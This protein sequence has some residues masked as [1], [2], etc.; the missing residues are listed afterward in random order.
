MSREFWWTALGAC[1]VGLGVIGFFHAFDRVTVMKPVRPEPAVMKDRYLAVTRT[2]ERLDIRADQVGVLEAIAPGADVDVVFVEDDRPS[3]SRRAIERMQAFVRAG[4]VVVLEAKWSGEDDPLLDAFGVTRSELRWT[5]ADDGDPFED[6]DEET[7]YEDGDAD[8]DADEDAG[9]EE[10]DADA[11]A[12]DVDYNDFLPWTQR[13][14]QRH[15]PDPNLRRIRWAGGDELIVHLPY[16]QDLARFRTEALL[17]DDHGA[18]ILRFDLGEGQVVVLND[19]DFASN[20]ELARNDHAEFVWRLV[21]LHA[22]PE[23]V[24]FYHADRQDLG[25]WLRKNAWAPLGAIG[26]LVLLL[27]WRGMPRFGP[28]ADDPQP[29]RRR[30][31][32]HLRAT[33]SFLAKANQREDI[34]AAAIRVALARVRREFPHIGIASDVEVRD[35]LVRQFQIQPEGAFLIATQQVPSGVPEWTRLMRACR[36]IHAA[37]DHEALRRT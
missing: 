26:L 23:R 8:E 31:L 17:A 13:L 3:V 32:D 21:H 2:L 18:Y 6:G 20:F 15:F 28:I 27:L 4:G 12:D 25:A 7:E 19:L 30:L 24:W 10:S 5:R 11:V 29:V 14:R 16:A 34:G 36:D 22:D 33:G 9:A 37:L 1:A 35:F